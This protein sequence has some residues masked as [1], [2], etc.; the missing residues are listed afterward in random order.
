M[1][2]VSG[3]AATSMSEATGEPALAKVAQDARGTFR[4]A[5]HRSNRMPSRSVMAAR[6][7]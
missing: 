1:Q 7:A 6:L 2:V 3:K 5:M 4:R